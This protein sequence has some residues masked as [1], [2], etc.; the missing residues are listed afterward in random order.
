MRRIFEARKALLSYAGPAAYIRGVAPFLYPHWWINENAEALEASEQRTLAEFSTVEIVL[1]RCD[2]V[3]AFD[4]SPQ[5]GRIAAPTLVYCARDDL[6]TPSYFSTALAERIPGARLEL[7]E[8]GGHVCS[9]TMPGPFNA[10]MLRFLL[11][12]AQTGRLAQAPARG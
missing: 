9:Q 12:L 7:A 11:P 6:L 5:L 2:A 10:S 4:R 3:L 1:S 8:R